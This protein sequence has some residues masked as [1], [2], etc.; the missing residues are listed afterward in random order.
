MTRAVNNLLGGL[1]LVAGLLGAGGM[2]HAADSKASKYYE[3]ALSRYEKKDLDGAIIQ[4][5]NALQI[6]PKQVQALVLLGKALLRN[7]DPI[8]AEVTFDEALRQGADRS[9]VL[10]LLAQAMMALGKQKEIFTQARFTAID[11]P[12]ATR[13][14]LL[15][16]RAGASADVGELAD[17]MK[18]I[19]AARAIDP[20]S[21]SSWIAEVPVRIRLRQF[22]EA[23]EAVDRATVMAPNAADTLYQKGAVRHVAGN[24]NGAIAAYDQAIKVD[25]D[26]IGALIA[27]AGLYVD[28]GRNTDAAKDLGEIRRLSPSEPRAAYLRA[29]LAEREKKPAEA[30]EALIEITELLDRFPMDYVRYRPQ[31]LMLNGLAHFG[32]NE[33]EKAK[34]YFEA[35]QNVQPDAPTAKMLAQIYLRTANYERAIEM[36]EKYLKTQPND[37]QAMALLGSALMGKGQ[38]AR[39]ASLMQQALETKDSPEIRKVLGL[40]LMRNGQPG[41]AIKE[42]EAAFTKDPRQTQAAT[43][44]IPLYFRSGQSLKALVLAEKLVK[45]QPTSPAFQTLLGMVRANM[46]NLSGARESFEHAI[47]LDAGFVPANLNL[48]RMEIASRSFDAATIRLAGIIQADHKNAEAIFEMATIADRQGK[49]AD[50]LSWLDKAYKLS[51]PRELRW[52]LALSDYQLRYG[53]P[54]PALEAAKGVSAKQPEN[55]LVL[56]ALA[57]AQLANN[58]GPGAKSTL[59]AATRIADYNP[60]VQVQ[61]AQMQ[62][63]ARNLP[64]ATYS[65]QK[66]LSKQGDFLPALVLMA[67]LDLRQGDV[68]KAEK[69]AREVLAKNPKRAVGN[70]LMGD[71]A[72]SKSQTAVAI[73]FYRRAFS[74]EPST[75]TFVKLYRAQANEGGDPSAATQLANLWLK[76]HSKDIAAQMEVAD[77]LARRNDFAA[78]RVAYENLVKIAPN[79][80]QALDSLANVLLRLKDPGAVKIAEQAVAINPSNALFIDT[81]GWALFQSGQL[82][83]SLKVLSDAKLRE[84]SNSEI[85][86]HRAVVLAQ[87]GLKNEARTELDAAL[88]TGTPFEGSVDAAALRKALN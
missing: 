9:D 10:P 53:A 82:E 2:S 11:L 80:S 58:D 7:Y 78:A 87:S 71:V 70:S 31:A 29:L 74:Q 12:A 38:S 24:I 54:G 39:A 42:L 18:H 15:L 63:A 35:F 72:L 27:R 6:E 41:A 88:K 5:K 57:K 83:R 19:N 75:L 26:H 79:N 17:A 56:L 60:A 49:P 50:A 23:N 64:G 4:L 84:P 69:R 25:S 55:L 77:S 61:I 45:L 43:A 21:P 34:I 47:K 32:L 36:L 3:D 16:L 48:A 66:A 30:R 67:E 81:L 13:A 51:G 86:Y 8:G 14:Q 68:G 46:A 37:G 40:S 76:A 44:L 73:D 22:K 62:V 59:I 20:Q 85:L 33:P 1:V 52:G 65:L 28:L